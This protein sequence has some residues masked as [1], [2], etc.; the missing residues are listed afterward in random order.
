MRWQD[1][2]RG[3]LVTPQQ[4]AALVK[5]GQRIVASLS[6]KPREVLLEIAKR[7]GELRGVEVVSHWNEDYPWLHPGMEESFRV[8][9]CFVLRPSREAVRDRRLDWVPVI[10]GLYDGVRHSDGRSS[11]Y[12]GADIFFLTLTPPN[13]RGYCSFGHAHWYSP[14]ALRTAATVVAQI[15]PGLPWTYGDTVHLSEIHYLIEAPPSQPEAVPPALPVPDPAEWEQAQ[16]IGALTADLVR[17][18]DTIQI[19]I[20]TPSEAVMDFLGGKN[21]L[22]MDSELIFP[23]ITQLIAQGVI[24]GARRNRRRGKVTTSCLWLYPNDPLG[25]QAIDFIHRNRNMEFYDIAHICRVPRIAANRNMVA[26]NTALAMD[27]V[28]QAVIDHLGPTPISGPGGQVEFC[29]GSHYSPG[30]RSITCL[31]STARGGKAS[32]IVP[33][34]DSGTVVQVPLSYIDYVV[35]ENGVVNLEGKSRRERAEAIISVAHPDF[36]PELRRAARHLF[37]P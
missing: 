1:R 25:R 29:V 28:G 19:G 34:L 23:R 7:A 3:K 37:W 15:D 8:K 22:G 11:P 6:L 10:F 31:L 35:T 9:E 14:T 4:A 17:D 27:L 12:H 36:Q 30:G 26:I 21:D 13:T 18:G 5:P 24:T 16:V 32:R 2:Y 33:Q 20:G